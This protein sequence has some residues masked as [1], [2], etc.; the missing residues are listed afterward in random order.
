MAEDLI[1]VLGLG[2]LPSALA[3]WLAPA[4]WL[5]RVL[6]KCTREVCAPRECCALRQ[7]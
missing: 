3:S 2:P 4:S 7:T 5:V 1:G 6:E